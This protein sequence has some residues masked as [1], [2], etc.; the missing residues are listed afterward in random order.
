MQVALHR[1]GR[2]L[3]ADSRAITSGRSA[4]K[5]LRVYYADMVQ[6]AREVASVADLQMR[7]QGIVLLG[8]FLQADPVRQ[9]KR[10]V[11]RRGLRGVEKALRKYFGKRGD[12][13]RAGQP[14]LRQ[15]RLQ[16][17]AGSPD[18]HHPGSPTSADH[19]GHRLTRDCPSS[20][21]SS[22]TDIARKERSMA[23][24]E[25]RTAPR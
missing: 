24:V 25:T 9:A 19:D 12:Q 3:A 21:D 13:R 11:R 20:V 2:G 18:G 10:D 22:A 6:I 17:D 5:R 16:R 4:S 23:T 14:D 15:A 7:M 1:P 8:A